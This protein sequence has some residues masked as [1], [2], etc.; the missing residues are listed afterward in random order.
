MKIIVAL[1]ACL[2]V[3]NASNGQTKQTASKD[4]AVLTG[5]TTISGYIRNGRNKPIKGVEAFVYKMDSSIIAS[6]NTDS[7]GH[8]ETNGFVPGPYFVKVV[9]PSRKFTLVTGITTKTGTTELN[10]KGDAPE[11]D[12]AFAYDVL[13]PKPDPKKD[14]KKKK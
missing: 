5:K 10:L 13:M 9:Y 7:T 6:G 11:A 14:M 1:S 3:F 4:K 12:T 2:F 8:F